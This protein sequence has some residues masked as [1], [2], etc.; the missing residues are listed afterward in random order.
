MKKG[1]RP[2]TLPLYI[3]L[4]KEREHLNDS[5]E[6]PLI[7]REGGERAPDKEKEKEENEHPIKRK[8]ERRMG[9]A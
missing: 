3:L 9:T 4:N 8:R 7:T 1:A 5:K 6:R 2:R